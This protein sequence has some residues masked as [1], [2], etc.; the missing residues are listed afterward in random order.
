MRGKPI[1]T[2]RFGWI[3]GVGAAEGETAMT[4][5]TAMIIT[6]RGELVEVEQPI[7]FDGAGAIFWAANPDLSERTR[8]IYSDAM[9]HFCLWLRG[10]GLD[11]VNEITIRHLIE[12]RAGW[13]ARLDA[14]ELT[15]RTL[16]NRLVGIRRFLKHL[17]IEGLLRQGLTPERIDAYLKSPKLQRGQVAP[18][19][20]NKEEIADLRG[21]I[22]DPRDQAMIT[23]ALG[24]GLRVSELVNLRLRHL[25]PLQ[26]GRALLRVEAGKGHKDREFTIP[27]K[28]FRAVRGYV[29]E[30]G[31]SFRR[32]RDQDALV[33]RS[34]QGDGLSERRVNQ[35]LARYSE[36]AGIAKPT[37]AHTLRHTFATQF[38]IGGGSVIVLN[39]ILGHANLDTTMIYAHIADMV[40]GQQW[41]VNWLK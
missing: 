20:L 12:Y 2:E 16:A 40:R 21:V 11:G 22:T 23:L 4:D 27:A 39:R 34:R 14:G 31:R 3:L 18:A 6:E 30:T 26:G 17:A 8:K 25:T 7:P 29:Q 10:Q 41:D 5:T 32:K 13:Q 33:F 1:A 38:L 36:A 9:G 19:W 35:L 15:R 37:S 28:V 24:A